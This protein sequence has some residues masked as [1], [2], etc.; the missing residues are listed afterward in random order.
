MRMDNKECYIK[1]YKIDRHKLI[2]NF[3]S[4][5]GDPENTRYMWL[6]QKFPV[7]FLYLASGKEPGDEISLVVVL[8]DGYD[9]EEVEQKPMVELSDPY[10]KVFTPGLWV[11]D[12]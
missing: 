8:A 9:K 3:P 10:T 12:D 7:S 4:M 5:P 6:W 1:G 2:N 11:R